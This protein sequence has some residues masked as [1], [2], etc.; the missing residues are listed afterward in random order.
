MQ[1]DKERIESQVDTCIAYREAALALGEARGM[2]D[3]RAFADAV[4][5]YNAAPFGAKSFSETVDAVISLEVEAAKFLGDAIPAGYGPADPAQGHDTGTLSRNE[6]KEALGPDQ[7]D[8]IA[9]ASPMRLAKDTRAM[10]ENGLAD[11]RAGDK[12]HAASSERLLG[13]PNTPGHASPLDRARQ[14]TGDSGVPVR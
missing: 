11:A 1:N 14:S 2:D 12:S 4:G 3:P 8:V 10:A 9:A 7:M 13:S 6:M 5:E